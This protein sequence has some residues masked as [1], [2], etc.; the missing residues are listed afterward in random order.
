[1]RCQHDR[2]AGKQVS[3]ESLHRQPLKMNDVGRPG[4]GF[5]AI[6]PAC[7]GT[8]TVAVVFGGMDTF[9]WNVPPS[10]FQSLAIVP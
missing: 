8:C 9:Q 10:L 6:E 1:M 7:A 4:L 5:M 3:I 2:S